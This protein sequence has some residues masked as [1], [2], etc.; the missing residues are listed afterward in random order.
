MNL[1]INSGFM[2]LIHMQKSFLKY[3]IIPIRNPKETNC[4]EGST[5]TAPLLLIQRFYTRK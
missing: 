3:G 5:L 2:V 4:F 1:Q